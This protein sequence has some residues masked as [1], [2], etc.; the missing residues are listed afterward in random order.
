MNRVNVDIRRSGKFRIELTPFG[1][2]VLFCMALFL[3][4][5]MCGVLFLR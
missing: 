3:A 1:W 2:M 4:G 5:F